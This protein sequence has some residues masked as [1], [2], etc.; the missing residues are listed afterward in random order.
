VFEALDGFDELFPGAGGEDVDFSH[1]AL[2]SGAVM[3][4]ADT[5]VSYTPRSGLRSRFRQRLAYGRG[6][7]INRVK[8]GGTITSTSMYFSA[9][10]AVRRSA[11]TLLR[12]RPVNLGRA[13][14]S[15]YDRYTSLRGEREAVR[16]LRC[17][18]C[19]TAAAPAHGLERTVDDPFLPVLRHRL[20]DCPDAG[21]AHLVGPGLETITLMI[22]T[23]LLRPG[24]TF[25]DGG[26]NIGLFSVAAGLTIGPTGKVI[27][28]EP[29]PT[30][31]AALT[32]NMRRHCPDVPFDGRK[33][34]LGSTTGVARFHR[35][36]NSPISSLH[37]A[38]D[39]SADVGDSSDFEVAVRRLDD[40][41]LH[42]PAVLK[43]DIEGS[44]V[45]AL[46]GGRRILAERR[47]AVIAELN[48]N[49]LRRAGR[50]VADLLD[51]FSGP[52]WEVWLVDDRD[53]HEPLVGP[54]RS[55]EEITRRSD[56]PCWWANVVA[57]PEAFRVERAIEDLRSYV[58]VPYVRTGRAVSR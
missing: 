2:R 35:D 15:G 13:I 1:R 25:A 4:T 39:G 28:F 21:A 52:D 42:A 47:T 58:E 23:E 16:V 20:F 14:W 10:L 9:F 12:D 7:A 5:S 6:G 49:A 55:A 24:D 38:R 46:E 50:T 22:L 40:E 41:I 53:P 37:G 27:A 34:A 48:P 31:A 44:E 33:V 30:I 8:N 57:L 54:D 29:L 3:A 43:L 19:N 11:A 56:D 51:I 32:D 36:E 26:A 17:R 45:D 18:P